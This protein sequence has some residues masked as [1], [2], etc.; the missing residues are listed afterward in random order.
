V[1]IFDVHVVRD[2][3][4]VDEGPVEG[5]ELSEVVIDLRDEMRRKKTS[6]SC[7]G[8]VQGWK[9]LLGGDAAGRRQ[10]VDAP[11]LLPKFCGHRVPLVGGQV[12]RATTLPPIRAS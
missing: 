11:N 1:T 10:R 5:P 4:A 7:R 2:G 6:P 9:V 12:R 3:V 8:H